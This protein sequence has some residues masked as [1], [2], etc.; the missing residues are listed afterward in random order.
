VTV[1]DVE[2]TLEKVQSL[3]GKVLIPPI[4]IPPTA[5]FALI[6]DLQEAIFVIISYGKLT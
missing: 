4:Q 2:E 5:C 6:Q 3:G 1:E